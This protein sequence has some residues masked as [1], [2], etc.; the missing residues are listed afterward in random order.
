MEILNILREKSRDLKDSQ[1][2]N[3]VL[4]DKFWDLLDK[5]KKKES[6]WS[7]LQAFRREFAE[8]SENEKTLFVRATSE[9]ARTVIDELDCEFE[10]VGVV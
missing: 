8:L 10:V 4:M 9:I 5:K 6:T 7:D 1:E 2:V 3:L